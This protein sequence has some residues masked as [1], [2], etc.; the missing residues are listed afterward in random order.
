MEQAKGIEPS[1]LDWKSKILPLNYTCKMMKPRKSKPHQCSLTQ[2][3]GIYIN[4]TINFTFPLKIDKR[5]PFQ[6]VG[7]SYSAVYTL[8][9]GIEY[10]NYFAFTSIL[11]RNFRRDS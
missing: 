8:K 7:H 10:K 11:T 5:R 4:K 1:T 3:R 9:I 2:T 6:A